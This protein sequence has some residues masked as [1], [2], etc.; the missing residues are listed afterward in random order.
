MFRSQKPQP[1]IWKFEQSSDIGLVAKNEPPGGPGLGPYSNIGSTRKAIECKR[2][3]FHTKS[4]GA[5]GGYSR[6]GGN[7]ITPKA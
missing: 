5:D 6:N 3:L 7:G 2:T 1:E 4:N